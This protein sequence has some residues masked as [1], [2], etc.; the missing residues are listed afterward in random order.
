MGS[1]PYEILQED[2]LSYF[3]TDIRFS[4]R[5]IPKNLYKEVDSNYE[6]NKCS[7]ICKL[8]SFTQ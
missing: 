1:G 3:E 6:T 5:V 8:L 7:N 4:L 2:I